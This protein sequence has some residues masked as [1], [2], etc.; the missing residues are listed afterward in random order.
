MVKSEEC[1]VSDSVFRRGA[2]HLTFRGELLHSFALHP[3]DFFHSTDV[4]VCECD[5]LRRE[6]FSRTTTTKRGEGLLHVSHSDVI[7]RA[8]E[9]HVFVVFGVGSFLSLVLYCLLALFVSGLRPP[10]ALV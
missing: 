7:A 5:S 3:F 2:F 8:F 10:P 6:R 9:F 1:S 4:T